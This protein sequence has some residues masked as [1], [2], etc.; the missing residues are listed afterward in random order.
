L[1]YLVIIW[2]IFPVLVC[3]TKKTLATLVVAR[4]KLNSVLRNCCRAT[5]KNPCY[6]IV[7]ARQ[8]VLRNY[9]RATKKN[10]CYQIDVV[11]QIVLRNCCRAT[12]C[13]TQLLSCDKKESM[14][15]N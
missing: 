1:V 6:R 9:C 7:V 15:P 8:I 4:I 10:P 12:N 14:L 2:D 3:S 13:F 11:R 5:K